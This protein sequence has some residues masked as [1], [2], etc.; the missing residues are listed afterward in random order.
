MNSKT[1]E[2]WI[3]RYIGRYKFNYIRTQHG[4]RPNFFIKMIYSSSAFLLVGST[5]HRN[6]GLITSCRRV[7][8]GSQQVQT[9]LYHILD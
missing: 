1:Y 3:E 6:K 8:L 4:V 5:F 2:I 7:Q 9:H